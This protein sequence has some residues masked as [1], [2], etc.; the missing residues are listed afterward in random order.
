M[1]DLTTALNSMRNGKACDPAGV[2]AEMLKVDCPILHESI[3]DLF[4]EAIQPNALFPEDWRTSRISVILKK[5]DPQLPGNYRP[6][7]LL[8][9]LYKLFS[10]MLC[11]R[12]K[13]II[14]PKLSM[15]QAAYRSAFSTEDHIL[16]STLAIE[17]CAEWNQELWLALID[18]EKAFDSVEHDTLW[19]AMHALRVDTHYIDMLKLLYSRQHATVMAGTESRQ[20]NVTRGGGQGDPISALLFIV[21]IDSILRS[22][23]SRWGRLNSHRVGQYYGLVIDDPQMPLTSLAFA[24]DI[25][26]FA[27]SAADIGK[28]IADL[29]AE[30]KKYG[31]LL[32][33]GK[34]IIMTNAARRPLHSI[35]CGGL[36]VQAAG[37]HDAHTYLGRKLSMADLHDDELSHRLAQGWK[38]FYKY[39]D[40]FCNRGIP[41]LDRCKLFNAVVTPSF[42]YGC[43]AWTLSLKQARRLVSAQRRMLRWTIGIKRYPEEDWVQYIR[44][45]THASE[46][47]ARENGCKSWLEQHIRRKWDF[48]RK[49]LCRNDGRW[50]ARLMPWKPWFRHVPH[51]GIG[52]PH[53]RWADAFAKSCGDNR[54]DI[55][56]ND[57]EMWALMRE[58]CVASF[59]ERLNCGP[60]FPE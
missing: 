39:K 24:D 40:L 41:I 14:I 31:L 11:A 54:A 37:F 46:A 43:C 26:L 58:A 59:V 35:N 22:L 23:K 4:N 53:Q 6:I 33:G 45:A 3:L 44:R 29:N 30:A 38:A 51:R 12:L 8:A 18:F 17:R 7:A 57:S 19:S 21:I 25:A 42:L 55:A 52:R 10:R 34:T 49:I 5:G 13:A 2:R 1:D 16:R 27:C 47:T 48:A 50:T 9:I 60:D 20:F 36:Q 15:D 56:A 28:M 32:H